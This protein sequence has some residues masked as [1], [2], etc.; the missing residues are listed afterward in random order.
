[1]TR[2]SDP[3][4]FWLTAIRGKLNDTINI[5]AIRILHSFFIRISLIERKADYRFPSHSHRPIETGQTFPQFII[6]TLQPYTNIKVTRY[7]N[8]QEDSI[9]FSCRIATEGNKLGKVKQ[10]E[11]NLDYRVS[12]YRPAATCKPD[13]PENQLMQTFEWAYGPI[14]PSIYGRNLQIQAFPKMQIQDI[15]MLDTVWKQ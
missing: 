9:L 12:R 10:M 13:I 15:Q 8:L 6:R 14:Y 4:D 7:V 5:S 3:Y 11:K 2:S 1:M